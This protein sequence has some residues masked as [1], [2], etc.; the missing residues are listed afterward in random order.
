MTTAADILTMV[1]LPNGAAPLEGVLTAGQPTA[2]QIRQLAAAGVRT[3]IDLRPLSEPRGFDEPA[4]ALD[5]GIAY[6]NVPV[7]PATLTDAEFDR[8][9]EILADPLQ[10]PVLVHCASANRVGA[11]L[12]PYLELDERRTAEDALATA[13]QIGLRSDDLARSARAYTAAHRRNETR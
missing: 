12:I 10:R 13:R 1:S 6:H 2:A 4:A 3:I 7:T 8:V 9:R 5:A 11:L